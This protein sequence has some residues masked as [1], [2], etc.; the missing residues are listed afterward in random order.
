MRWFITDLSFFP[1][2]F[3][4]VTRVTAKPIADI[5]NASYASDVTAELRLGPDLET[6]R[7]CHEPH[8]L[9]RL[10]LLPAQRERVP[11]CV[12]VCVCVCVCERA[13]K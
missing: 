7:L 6:A 5:G 12:C 3:R 8:A 4:E 9:V 11:L 10:V 13:S 1:N 2:V